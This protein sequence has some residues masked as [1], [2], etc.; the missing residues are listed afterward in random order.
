MSDEPKPVSEIVAGIPITDSTA[1]FPAELDRITKP[2]RKS[3]LLPEG[4]TLTIDGRQFR[5]EMRVVISGTK[6]DIAALKL[7]ELE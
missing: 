3:T 1:A 2:Q 5:L 6:D 4:Y 7:Q